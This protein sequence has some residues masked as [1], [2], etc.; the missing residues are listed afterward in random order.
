MKFRLQRQEFAE[1]VAWTARSIPTRLPVPVLAGL[2]LQ[3]KDGQL[4]LSGFDYEVSTR[5][6]LDIQ[7]FE[8]GSAV[9][10]GRLLA[11]I[12]KALPAKPVDVELVGDSVE[13]TCGG[14]QFTLPTLPL[15]DYPRLPPMPELAGTIKAAEFSTAVSRVTIAAGRDET[16]PMLT[17]VQVEMA[18]DRIT[19]SATDRYRLAMTEL[20]WQPERPDLEMSA[21]IPAKA[22][23]DTARALGAAGGEVQLHLDPV[24]TD[25]SLVG[26]GSQSR[27]TTSRIMSGP[28]PNVRAIFP[29][30]HNSRLTIATKDLTDV[31]HR[32]ALVTDRGNPLRLQV[33][34]DELVIEAGG[35]GSARA[36]EAT[37][38]KL[39]GETLKIAINPQFML[40]GLGAVGSPN[41]ILSFVS[42]HKPVMMLPADE[43][44]EVIPGFRYVV[45]SVRMPEG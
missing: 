7:L 13:L 16:L 3:A 8:E 18:G 20:A 28:Y 30:S 45:M 12:T 31:V 44:G 23:S 35:Q 39:E 6:D 1:A 40:D 26:L 15:E 38:A 43:N 36:R 4:Q 34:S 32:I 25:Q 11:E 24:A 9:V 14:A 33:D 22:L 42:T 29:T 19:M 17:G 10:A 27:Q 2:L 5:C 41:V 37:E 21:L